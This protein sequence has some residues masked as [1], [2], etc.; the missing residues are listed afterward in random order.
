MVRARADSDREPLLGR[1]ELSR[2]KLALRAFEPQAERQFVLAAPVAFVQQRHA[3]R[4][5]DARRRIG[6]RRLG[7][8]PGTQIDRR[9]LR[10]LV[11]VDQPRGAPIEAGSRHR[12]DARRARPPSC[13]PAAHGRCAGGR[14]HGA[15]RE[16]ANRPPAGSGRAGICRRCPRGTT[17]P[18]WTASQSAAC[19]ASSLSR[20]PGPGWRSR[21]HCPG[22]RAV[23]GLP[24]WWQSNRFSFPAMRSTT[25]SV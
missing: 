11:P 3:G 6:R 21:R 15:L 23:S 24:G 4:E 9:H 18:A 19:I 2:Q 5:I 8:S 22:R 25:L 7:L 16:S 10:F 12:T 14:R 1:R 20:E 13:S 17:S